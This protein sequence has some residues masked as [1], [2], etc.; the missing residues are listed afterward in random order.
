MLRL[1]I[2]SAAFATLALTMMRPAAADTITVNGKRYDDVLVLKTSAFYY[3]QLPD[4]GR[5]LSVPAEDVDP[6]KVSINDD[7]FYRD[8]L[9]IEYD[10][11]REAREAN[12]NVQVTDPAFQA[13]TSSGPSQAQLDALRGGGGGG[14]GASIPRTQ[15]EQMLSNFGVQFQDGPQRNGQPSRVARMPD[16]TTIELVGPPNRLM[17]LTVKGQ[18]TPQQ[19][20]MFQNQI[21]M[22]AGQMAPS[23]AGQLDS[24]FAEAKEKGRATLTMP[25]GQIR[26]MHTENAGTVK[27][28][29]NLTFGN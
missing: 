23:A 11:N 29:Y 28:E 7:P 21:K 26:V 9:K 2:A 24:L 17:G 3:I 14:A 12:E 5:T 16:G 6:A 15:F 13:D 10:R 27:F 8:K 1:R 25:N 20:A 4:E 22:T 19:Y 18:G